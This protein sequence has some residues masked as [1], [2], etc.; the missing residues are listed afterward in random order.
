MA[1]LTFKGT[2]AE[3]LAAIGTQIDGLTKVT[4]TDNT[5][6]VTDL[7]TINGTASSVVLLKAAGI[8][9]S[10]GVAD[11]IVALDGIK[12]TG[13]ITLTDATVSAAD[14]NTVAKSTT[15]K[16]TAT[17]DPATTIDATTIA[18]LKD[19]KTTDSITLVSSVT[20]VSNSDLTALVALKKLIPSADFS[21]VTN[22][23]A[24]LYEI[25][26]LKSALNVA[27]TA[28]VE[29]TGT[30]SAAD[31]NAIA[32]ATTG[33]VTATVKDGSVSATLKAL[34][35]V[36]NTDVIT[37]TT[38]DKTINARDLVALDAKVANFTA[39]SVQTITENST[40]LGT[41]AKN[42]TDA[43]LI[44]DVD[45]KIT[46]TISATTAD[47]IANAA[48]GVVTATIAAGTASNLV[49]ALTNASAT[50][51]LTL[52][53]TDKT[54]AAADLIALDGKTSVAV[55]A[56]SVTEVTG[57]VADITTLYAANAAKTVSGLGNE[58]IL[59]TAASITATEANDIAKLT[60][61]KVTATVTADTADVLLATLTDAKATDALTLQVSAGT[62][63]A[64]DLKALDGKTSVA[65]DA[66]L[67]TLITGSA[68]DVKAVLAA[69]G[70]DTAGNV[71]VTVSSTVS[72]ADAN[73][74]TGA[75]L[76]TVTATVAAGTA[77]SLNATLKNASATD[78]LT[79]K[80]TGTT[81][82]AADLIA[83]DGKTSVA[84][85]ANAVKT[86]TGNFADVNT[87]LTAAGI[88]TAADVAATLSG[89]VS[90]ANAD[91]IALLT[92]G[93]VTATVAADTAANL[94]TALTDTNENAYTLTVTGTT[95]T[96]A[97][98]IA[99]DAK[100][101]VKVK[102]DATAVTGTFA[103]LEALYVTNKAGYANLGNE[104][105]TVTGTP[106]ASQVN[107]IAK[108]TTGVVTAAV[109]ANTADVLVANL[110]DATA[111]DALTLTVN[112]TAKATDL[113]TLDG[114]TSVNLNVNDVTTITGT[115]ADVKKVYDAVGIAT[116]GD[117][118]IILTG[119]VSAADANTITGATTGVVTA[120]V[121]A[122]TAATLNAALTNAAATDA[123]TLTVNGTT[124]TAAD[125]NALDAKTSVNI[126]VDATEVTGIFT[127]LETL[128][129]TN[130]PHFANL[131][132]ENV[133]ITDVA[134]VSAANVNT[135]AAA[136]TGKVTA[137]VAPDTATALKAALTDAKG[138][139]ALTLTVT[140]A[141]ATA[142][143][144]KTL[145]ALTSVKVDATAL[146]SISGS[147]ADIKA[148]LAAKTTIGLAPSVP[149]TVDGTVS[150]SDISAILKGTSGIVTATVNGATAAA[151]K[152]ALS[153]ADVNDALT[154][155][156][157]G[158]TATAADLIALDGK[159]SVDV[160]VDASSVTGSIADLIN[161]YVT[162]AAN[163]AGLGDEAITVSGTISA[164]DADSIAGVTTGKVTATVSAATASILDTILTTATAT[165]ALKLTVSGTSADAANLV[166]LDGKTSVAVD[167]SAI[168]N[169]SGD[170]ADVKAAYDANANKT[171]SGL[172]NE[173]VDL[174]TAT[175]ASVSLVKAINDFTTGVITLDTVNV[176]AGNF[177]LSQLGDLKGITGLNTLDVSAGDTNITLS[178]KDLLASNDDTNSFIFNI[179]N[180]AAGDTVK[181]A[182]T[183]GWTADTTNSATGVTVYTNDV[184]SQVITI[185]HTDVVVV[186]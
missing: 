77:A 179:D 158:S 10:G 149:V 172:G 167:A 125:L 57:D 31:V 98:L 22:L 91:A 157:N 120:I 55:N 127:D 148:V 16:V 40:T 71:A 186:A 103:Q 184:T 100:T 131:G 52:T 169:I 93:K 35:D 81:A 110:K 156:V 136:T 44:A 175:D 56:S 94:N 24:T 87:A 135:I 3:A 161:V 112:G 33:A 183:T 171:I 144:L 108:A 19:V 62:A 163:F 147:A 153:S 89:T 124:A 32:K 105:V 130:A 26:A 53:V 107:I 1:L 13:A 140:G 20:T 154:L 38:T 48:T 173:T 90:A 166:S 42:V 134:A 111:T 116:Q 115:A 63:T 84:V 18:A 182:D 46:G 185:N 109:A 61:G 60:T 43:L 85:D 165:D 128:Y 41:N 28:A 39:P 151:L 101:S 11:V 64:A 104:N 69:S 88:N 78:A 168:K 137:T 159:T 51:A 92:T 152:A 80:V 17:L 146:T 123:L 174:S 74:I 7:V 37:F 9:L 96:A 132:N 162:N 119:T 155:T 12:Y 49:A 178:L 70:I 59:V 97:H 72:A 76:G 66:S 113:L 8:A 142:A 150:A 143:D 2:T 164:T 23:E 27:K 102:V 139:D 47:I 160:Q 25:S 181:F 79:L 114:K 29:V 58:N 118:N 50:D 177:S 21:A 99:L 65:V 83:L 180:G 5:Y 14:L 141:T 121:A 75:T 6:T 45:V 68:A 129:V 145:D 15:G 36:K 122:G 95:A 170:A 82:A 176:S 133:K 30:I 67:V 54:V 86:I 117:E 126:K 106:L 73:T 34:A 138:T 4:I